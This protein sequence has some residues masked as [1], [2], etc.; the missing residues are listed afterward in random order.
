MARYYYFDIETYGIGQKPNP[1]DD[2]IITMQFQEVDGSTGKPKTELTILKEWE[3]S[4][5]EIL[6]KFVSIFRPWNFIPIGNNLTF[7]RNFIRSKCQ[8]YKIQDLDG[9]GDLEYE[10]PS[11][12]IHS[13]FVILN[14]GEFKGSGMHNFTEKETG[15]YVIPGYYK[16]K[17]YEKIEDYIKK[18]TNAF[19]KFYQQCLLELP[20]VFKRK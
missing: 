1:K 8:K 11:I 10:F 7:E 3:S 2:K 13:L 20:I 4:E 14:S 5:E 18:E 17:E 16:N 6:R 19:L 15:G 12:D 9:Y